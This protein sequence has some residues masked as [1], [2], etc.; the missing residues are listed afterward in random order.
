VITTVAGTG[1]IGHIG[2]GGAATSALFDSIADIEMSADSA[3]L[4]ADDDNN[5]V[6]LIELSTGNV[7]TV[8]G[9]GASANDGD[10]ASANDGDGGTATAASLHSPQGLAVEPNGDVLV[11]T[12]AMLRRFTIGGNISHIA[13]TGNQG[14]TGEAQ[15]ATEADST[16]NDV[17]LD[18]DSGNIL[19]ST[20]FADS[21]RRI[22]NSGRIYTIAGHDGSNLGQSHGDGGPAPLA[23]MNYTPHFAINP[24]DN[25]IYVAEVGEHRIR[26]ITLP[27]EDP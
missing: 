6:R 9:D 20:G 7:S 18:P 25:T 12:V 4:I 10:G 3:L 22:T 17:E 19:M 27:E 8:A 11:A 5:R 24:D 14:Q 1:V 21:I 16:P 26:I 13:G 2:D 23:Y 15:L